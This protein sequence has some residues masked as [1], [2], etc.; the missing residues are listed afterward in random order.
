MGLIDF[1]LNWRLAVDLRVELLLNKISMIDTEEKIKSF[2]FLQKTSKRLINEKLNRLLHDYNQNDKTKVL[3]VK[4]KLKKKLS[5]LQ[6]AN[7]EVLWL[8]EDENT[9]K[10]YQNK[11]ENFEIDIKE[12]IININSIIWKPETLS[13]IHPFIPQV[14]PSPTSHQ[15]SHQN[16]SI[17]LSQ[18]DI[19]KFSGDITEWQTF[20]DSFEFA[21]HSN[22]KLSNIKKM[23]YLIS[24]LTG[25]AL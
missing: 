25:E 5:T 8:M 2:K 23:N 7:N 20:F 21:A 22:N 1:Y 18:I 6:K 9:Y 24:Y 14:V 16:Y 3:D 11:T 10:N 17:K 4:S 13:V 12:V 19:E 15:T